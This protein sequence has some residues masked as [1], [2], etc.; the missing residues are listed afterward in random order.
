MTLVDGARVFTADGEVQA[1]GRVYETDG[2][3]QAAATATEVGWETEN[4]VEVHD[5]RT[6]AS[7]VRLEGDRASVH[8]AGDRLV[9]TAGGRDHVVA[10]TAAR[11]R[12]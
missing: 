7:V 2:L 5:R 3:P 11:P 9:I 6:G 8:A 12:E 1:D 4:G 10:P